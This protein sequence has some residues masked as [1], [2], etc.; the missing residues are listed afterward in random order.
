MGCQGGN[1]GW[2]YARQV[3]SHCPI[4]LGPQLLGF[5]SFISPR[6]CYSSVEKHRPGACE[7]PGLLTLQ[8]LLLCFTATH[9]F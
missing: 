9:S 7:K 1:Q 3:H 8:K 4:S 6:C 5:F 2:L